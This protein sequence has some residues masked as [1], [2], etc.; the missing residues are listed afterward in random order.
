[1]IWYAFRFR[2]KYLWTIDVVHWN[3]FAILEYNW[4]EKI[5]DIMMY[6]YMSYMSSRVEFKLLVFEMIKSL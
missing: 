2:K 5:F 6:M 4:D 1:M 3:N